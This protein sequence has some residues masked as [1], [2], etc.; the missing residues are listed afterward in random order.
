MGSERVAALRR[1]RYRAGLRQVAPSLPGLFSWGVVSGLAL[2]KSGLTP[3]QA[4]GMT[5]TVF[6]GTAQ[7]AALP[8]IASGASM[9]LIAV[10]TVLTSLRFIVYSASISR[11]LS[12]LHWPL[13]ALLGYLTTDNGLAIYQMSS[14]SDRRRQ[15]V[16]FLLGCNT[17]VWIV[18]QIGSAIGILLATVLPGSDEL[19]Y[20]G[21]LAVLAIV[22]QMTR[23]RIAFWAGAS[24][25]VIAVVG[26]SWPF[27]GGM[28]AGIL[29]GVVVALVLEREERSR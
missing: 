27:N 7:L 18:W 9:L 5:L 24:A 16:A 2:V 21:L 3:A 29:A 23:N 19:V 20:L 4:W 28:L 6:S 8:L 14:R 22:V 1:L 10:T 25:A 26:A 13:R 12:R 11:D 15:R 17:P